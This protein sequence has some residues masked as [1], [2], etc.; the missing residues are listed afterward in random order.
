MV[1]TYVRSMAAVLVLAMA[2]SLPAHAGGGGGTSKDTIAIQAQLQQLIDS[3]ARLQQANDERMGVLKNLVEQNADAVNKMTVTV[4]G[5]K[6]QIANASEASAT[7]SDAVSGQV[8]SL[9]DQLDEI[10]ARLQRMEKT[11]GD[12]QG[13]QQQTNAMLA[14]LPQ[15]GATAA[16]AGP[17]PAATTGGA[18]PFEGDN[19]ATQPKSTSTR[20]APAARPVPTAGPSSGEMYRNAYSDFMSGKNALATSEFTDLIKAYP[21]DNLSGNGYFYLGEI[22]SRANKPSVAIKDYDQTIEHFPNNAKI[23]AAHLHKADALIAMKSNAAAVLELKALIARFP[24]SPEAAQAKTKL[25]TL[26]RR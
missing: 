1:R 10:K 5:L 12:V 11:M 20:N 7:K 2:A 3:V 25:A 15:P 19:P 18:S 16:P 23:P 14:S 6:L 21:D 9:N 13:Q 4:N 22:A 8:Q 26:S 17:A 24:N